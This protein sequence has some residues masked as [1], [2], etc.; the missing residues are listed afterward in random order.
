M[1][2]KQLIVIIMIFCLFSAVFASQDYIIDIQKKTA[3][4]DGYRSYKKVE[5]NLMGYSVEGGSL[6][7]YFQGNILSKIVATLYGEMYKEIEAF[8]FY[9][10]KLIFVAIKEYRYDKPFGNIKK[11][12]QWRYF[13]LNGRLEKLLNEDNKEIIKG[14]SEFINTEER[15][16]KD[17]KDFIGRVKQ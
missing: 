1:Y 7:G 9:E 5:K 13:F 14:S 16:L 17:A 2:K 10:E 8:Y 6:T 4:I 3:D 15:I 11:V 12:R